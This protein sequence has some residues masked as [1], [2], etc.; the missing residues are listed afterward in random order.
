MTQLVLL[1]APPRAGKDTLVQQLVPY[2]K[3]SHL[4]FAAPIKRMVAG[5]LNVDLR[6]I[7]N[8]KEEKI[9]SLSSVLF[10]DSPTI[11]QLLIGLSEDFMKVHY[12]REVFGNLLWNEAKNAANKLVLVSDCGFASEVQRVIYRAGARNCLLV[13]IHRTGTDFT[14]DSRSYLPDGM[15][16][17]VDIHNDKTLHWLTLQGLRVIMNKFP[18]VEAMKEINWSKDFV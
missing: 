17:T 12:G 3:F 14:G 5:L 18:A 15:C 10:D 11:R 16:E 9:K 7:E 13:R 8:F 4:K 1:N 2:L 6:H